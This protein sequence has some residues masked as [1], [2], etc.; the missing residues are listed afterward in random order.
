MKRFDYM[1]DVINRYKLDWISEMN[2]T[3]D[4]L[5]INRVI[6]R[7]DQ[8]AI[9]YESRWGVGRLEGLASE[10]LALKWRSQ[11]GKINQAIED[12][13]SLGM[14][15]LMQ[16][17]I[18]GWKALEDYALLQ[19]HQPNDPRYVEYQHKDGVLYKICYTDADARLL[20]RFNG[21][22]CR[23]VTIEEMA[24]LM[25]ARTSQA[26]EIKINKKE[27]TIIFDFD[28]GDTIPI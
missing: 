15:S 1:R 18:R 19:G 23:V 27:K 14:E 5:R 8:A 17:A 6:D 22:E 13:N 11:I 3:P 12:R 4:E 24:N 10:E 25:E 2:A 7:L 9:D 28:K 16:G 21:P 26:F 20:D